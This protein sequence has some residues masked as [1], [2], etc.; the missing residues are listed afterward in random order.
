MKI[1]DDVSFKNAKRSVEERNYRIEISPEGQVG[2][3]LRVFDRLLPVLGR[4]FWSL[5]VAPRL[6]PEFICADHPVTLAFKDQR[7]GQIGFGLKG[8]EV[9]F[10]FGRRL[11][12]Y[13]VFEN[14]LDPKF[15]LDPSDVA[16]LNRRTFLN[17]ERHVYSTLE[18]FAILDE[19]QIREIHC[20][21]NPRVEKDAVD[22]TSHPKR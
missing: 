17:A 15:N 16:T 20:G 12:F 9:F 8:T 22:C 4:R 2:T 11:G 3:D 18:R 10:P 1:R 7:K 5:L 13:G 6:G 21:S 19:G 14:P